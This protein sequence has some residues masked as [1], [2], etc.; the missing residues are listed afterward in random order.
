VVRAAAAFGVA[1]PVWLVLLVLLPE[2]GLGPTSSFAIATVVA[3]ALA[4]AGLRWFFPRRPAASAREREAAAAPGAGR[5]R[6]L[7]LAGVGVVA[8]AYLIFV[9]RAAG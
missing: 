7:V 5:P 8:L 6:R 2:T 9:L 4:Y 1:S 3:A